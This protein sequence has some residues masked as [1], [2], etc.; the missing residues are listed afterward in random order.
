[1]SEKNCSYHEF[2]VIPILIASMNIKTA[3]E[4]QNVACS[5]N[6]ICSALQLIANKR[7]CAFIVFKIVLLR[8]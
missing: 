3:N 1:M 4:Y 7:Y 8:F 6:S 2:I 5:Y